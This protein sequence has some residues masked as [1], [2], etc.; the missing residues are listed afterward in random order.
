MNDMNTRVMKFGV[1]KHASLLVLG[2]VCAVPATEAAIVG[3]VEIFMGFSPEVEELFGWW[4]ISVIYFSL[5]FLLGRVIL[6]GVFLLIE[7]MSHTTLP[8]FEEF[9]TLVRI[10]KYGKVVILVVN[11]AY[12]LAFVIMTLNR[13]L[14]S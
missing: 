4:Y 2:A 14:G 1:A 9:A 3:L 6:Q 10:K 12:V 7:R 11:L 8:P 13:V 5:L